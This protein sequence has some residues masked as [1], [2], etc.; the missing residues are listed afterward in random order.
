MSF[1]LT[2]PLAEAAVLS[3]PG[4]LSSSAPFAEARRLIESGSYDRASPGERLRLLLLV[5]AAG[6]RLTGAAP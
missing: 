6:E 2:A 4:R 1:D 5:I 3:L